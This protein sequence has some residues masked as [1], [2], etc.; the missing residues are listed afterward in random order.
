MFKKFKMKCK[1]LRG[2]LR[3]VMAGGRLE[4]VWPLPADPSRLRLGCVAMPRAA[5]FCNLEA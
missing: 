3:G 5:T 2:N 4:S 1:C